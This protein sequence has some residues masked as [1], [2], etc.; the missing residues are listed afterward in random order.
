MSITLPADFFKGSGAK[1]GYAIDNP[2]NESSEAKAKRADFAAKNIPLWPHTITE[3]EELVNKM[4]EIRNMSAMTSGPA[5]VPYNNVLALMRSSGIAVAPFERTPAAPKPSAPAPSSKVITRAE[6]LGSEIT[7]KD[8]MLRPAIDK[9][10]YKEQIQSLANSINR[11]EILKAVA[12]NSTTQDFWAL[13]IDLLEVEESYELIGILAARLLL[14]QAQRTE[15][16]VKLTAI[17]VLTNKAGKLSVGVVRLGGFLGL[18]TCKGEPDL[19]Q[20]LKF[21]RNPLLGEQ[22]DALRITRRAGE[23]SEA[24]AGRKLDTENAYASY[25]AIMIQLTEHAAHFSALPMDVKAKIKAATMKYV[26][27]G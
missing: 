12:R 26:H 4:I 17:S 13:L 8:N 10:K 11:L 24:F 7:V 6:V 2:A 1:T 21:T 18:A 23:S 19:A 14:P 20:A 5:E 16:D 15:L 25:R 9:V 27:S 22:P 3:P